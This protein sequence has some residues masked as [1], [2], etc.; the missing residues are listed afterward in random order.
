[1]TYKEAIEIITNLFESKCACVCPNHVGPEEECSYNECSFKQA[2]KY[3]TEPLKAADKNIPLLVYLDQ[4]IILTDDH[5][6]VLK[7]YEEKQMVKEV[8]ER[9]TESFKENGN[10]KID[11]E[12]ADN[13][14]DQHI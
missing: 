8:V 13:E 1:M 7:K 10:L 12:E 4:M 6:N 9:L 11:F 3:A 14:S 5:I 2:Y